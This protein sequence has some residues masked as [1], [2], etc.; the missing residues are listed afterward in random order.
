MHETRLQFRGKGSPNDLRDTSLLAVSRPR[1]SQRNELTI[2]WRLCGWGSPGRGCVHERKREREKERER[3]RKR[4]RE[5][6]RERESK[7]AHEREREKK[8]ERDLLILD[9]QEGMTCITMFCMI[10]NI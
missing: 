2:I 4:E 10:E 1:P 8:R 5:R 9:S 3:K 6:E 7:S